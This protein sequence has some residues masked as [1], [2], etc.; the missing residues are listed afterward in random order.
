MMVNQFYLYFIE[1]KSQLLPGPEQVMER[2]LRLEAPEQRPNA[3][4]KAGAN[5]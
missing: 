3:T 4:A 1:I 2:M 5:A